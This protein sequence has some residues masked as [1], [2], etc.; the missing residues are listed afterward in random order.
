VLPLNSIT[1]R[2][3]WET[4]VNAQAPVFRAP[5]A[6]FVKALSWGA[7]IFLVGIS[8]LQAFS[9]PRELL[10]GWPWLLGTSLPAGVALACALFVIR[11]YAL[12][13]TVLRIQRLLWETS[14]PLESLQR[15]WASPE[16]MAGSLRLFG[17]GGLF[18]VTGLLR[19]ER[20]GKYRAF[21]MDPKRAV[22]L[23]FSTRKIVVTPDSPEIFLHQLQQVCPSVRTT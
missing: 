23:E 6:T 19:N 15:A 20:L 2:R 11:G 13:P 9:L 10:G 3:R 7:T 1:V 12:E 8:V 5:W 4:T 17:N 18:S 22:V 21:A 14:I 16:A